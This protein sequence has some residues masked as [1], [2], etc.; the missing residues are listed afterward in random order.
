MPQEQERTALLAAFSKENSVEN[1]PTNLLLTEYWE[2]GDRPLEAKEIF[3]SGHEILNH[4]G[5]A[6]N[7]NLE[8]LLAAGEAPTG[9]TPASK[10]HKKEG[11]RKEA[12][13][14]I[15]KDK[16]SISSS[17]NQSRRNVTYHWEGVDHR[18]GKNAFETLDIDVTIEPDQDYMQGARYEHGYEARGQRGQGHV[19]N[20]HTLSAIDNAARFYQ[21]IT[22]ILS[23]GTSVSQLLQ[24]Q[25]PQ[26]S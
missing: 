3:E 25:T 18:T 7:N 16:F 4:F 6:F 21:R 14:S 26:G 19:E 17:A 13:F 2:Y 15:G 22:T 10:L 1:S 5:H 12:E 20:L 11:V 8:Y 9:M 23:Q 24:E